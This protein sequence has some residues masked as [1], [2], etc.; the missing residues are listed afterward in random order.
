[1]C[2]HPTKYLIDTGE[3]Q[4]VQCNCPNGFIVMR[5][6]PLVVCRLCAQK[7]TIDDIKRGNTPVDE[8]LEA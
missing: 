5:N 3:F 6:K 8:E 1:M 4:E 2:K 7:L